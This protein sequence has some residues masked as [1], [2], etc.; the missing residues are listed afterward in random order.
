MHNYMNDEEREKVVKCNKCN[1]FFGYTKERT[2]CPFCHTEYRE[3]EEK[4][5]TTRVL[6]VKTV[7]DSFKMWKGGQSD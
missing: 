4:N 1:S 2:K 3:V 7:K 6:P 5:K